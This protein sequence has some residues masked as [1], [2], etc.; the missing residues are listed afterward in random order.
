MH[1]SKRLD[2]RINRR[3]EGTD[4]C[5]SIGFESINTKYQINI[6]IQLS[7]T[8]RIEEL[9]ER[10]PPSLNFLLMGVTAFLVR[11][12]QSLESLLYCC[13]ISA[14]NAAIP[15]YFPLVM[16]DVSRGPTGRDCIFVPE[17]QNALVVAEEPVDIFKASLGC[18]WVQKIHGWHK[19]EV[20]NGPDYVEFPLQTL[21][22][23]W[24]YLD[25]CSV[26]SFTIPSNCT[27]CK[28]IPI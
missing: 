3:P 27:I 19:G 15:P 25:H 4:A 9:E 6:Y 1:A 26:I 10:S 18:F 7:D 13:R 2:H 8:R 28:R 5:S 14:D 17:Y 11:F 22:A 24:G 20:E 16:L 21:N 12:R 23:D